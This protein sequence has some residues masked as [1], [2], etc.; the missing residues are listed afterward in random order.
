M[1]PSRP[2][3]LATNG[4]SSALATVSLLEQAHELIEAIQRLSLCRSLASV[5][6]VVRTTARRLMNAD[7]ATFVLREGRFCFYA[8][9]DA[10]S[11]LWKGQRFPLEACISGWSMLKREP[12]VIEDIYADERIPHDAYRPTFVKSLVMVPIRTIDPVGAIGAYWAHRHRATGEEVRLVQALADSTAIA[13]E[14]I[15][16]Y[17]ELEESRLE[18]LQRLAI[19]AEYRDAATHEHTVRVARTAELLGARL[20]LGD[21]DVAVLGQAA[22]LHDVGKIAVPD[23]ILLKRGPLSAEE[24]EQVKTHTTAGAAILEGSRSE[25]LRVAREICLGH[26]EWWDGSGYPHGLAGAEIPLSARIVAL[27]DV[28]DALT[29]ERPYHDAWPVAQALEHVRALDGRQFDPA[30]VEAFVRLEVHELA[31]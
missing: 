30:V 15:R 1:D 29:H 9:E 12:A 19:A 25:V 28:F 4:G 27:A 23:G 18:T 6:E 8:D 24:F 26:H 13:L 10:V 16:V 14:N 2:Q 22:M 20:G 3:A 7:G 11:P 31:S 17:E 21:R 5:Q